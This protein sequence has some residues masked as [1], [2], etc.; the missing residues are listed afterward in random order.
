MAI[1]LREPWA[2][3]LIYCD[4]DGFAVERRQLRAQG[5]FRRGTQKPS[6]EGMTAFPREAAACLRERK[7]TAASGQVISFVPP[8]QRPLS[9]RILVVAAVPAEVS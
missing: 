5:A 4:M 9:E 8:G 2:K 7:R 3:G 6:A 1:A